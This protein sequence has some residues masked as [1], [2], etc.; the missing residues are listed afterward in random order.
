MVMRKQ[1]GPAPFELPAGIVFSGMSMAMVLAL[2]S[3]IG[4]GEAVV[5]GL[6]VVV[7][8]G[9]WNRQGRNQDWEVD[10]EWNMEFTRLTS[11][12]FSAGEAFELYNGIGFHKRTANYAQPFSQPRP[13]TLR[14]RPTARPYMTPSLHRVKVC[15]LSP[16]NDSKSLLPVFPHCCWN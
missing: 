11:F 16:T 5:L 13:R 1:T 10:A 9:N 4:K 15:I 7:A 2:L 6:T 14:S 12:T 8:L 3:H